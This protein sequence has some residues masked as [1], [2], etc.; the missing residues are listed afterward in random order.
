MKTQNA[1]DYFGSRKKLADA[2]ELWPQAVYRWGDEVPEG[3]A[4]KLQV[5]TN[6]ELMVKEESSRD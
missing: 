6:G 2:L 4:Y 3:S 1:I 5:I